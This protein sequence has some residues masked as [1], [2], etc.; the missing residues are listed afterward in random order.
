MNLV[1]AHTAPFSYFLTDA[2][3]DGQAEQAALDWLD[4]LAPWRLKRTD[5]YEQFEFSLF[6]ADLPDALAGLIS[7]KGLLATRAFI[8]QALNCSLTDRIEVVAHKLVEGQ[9]IGIHNDY[10]VG[11]ETHRLTIQ[12][13]RGLCDEDGG[14]FMLFNSFDAGDVHRIMRPVSNTGVGFAI[15]P[16]SHHAVS[17]VHSGSRYTLVY[18]F[19]AQ[20]DR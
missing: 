2:C 4:T 20:R 18:S 13:N 17:R 15:G 6:D 12:L 10:L 8:E 14:F 16:T 9:R 3:L 11:E 7:P 5:F 19:H 1:E